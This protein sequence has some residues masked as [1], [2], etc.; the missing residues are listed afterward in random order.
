MGGPL[1]GYATAGALKKSWLGKPMDSGFIEAFNSKLRA[2]C[3]NAQWFT[4]STDSL[5]KLNA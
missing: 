3:L 4:S 2:E 5:K 1:N